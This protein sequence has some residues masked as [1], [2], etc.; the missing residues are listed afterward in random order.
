MGCQQEEIAGLSA[1]FVYQ[2]WTA[3]WV[4]VVLGTLCSTSLQSMVWIAWQDWTVLVPALTTGTLWQ[5]LSTLSSHS[6]VYRTG[7]TAWCTEGRTAWWP[8]NWGSASASASRF[9]FSTAESSAAAASTSLGLQILV[10]TSTQFSSNSTVWIGTSMSS[11]LLS[12]LG[13]QD[14]RVTVSSTVEQLG[15]W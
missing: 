12:I 13:A 1:V 10:V 3:A 14:L 5:T 9:T 11:H 15:A 8:K 4:Q 2:A 6:V 7:A